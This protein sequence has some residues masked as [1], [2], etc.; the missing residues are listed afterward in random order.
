MLSIIGLRLAVCAPI[1][2]STPNDRP[3]LLCP[4]VPPLACRLAAAQLQLNARRSSVGLMSYLMFHSSETTA[5]DEWH[6]KGYIYPALVN[7]AGPTPLHLAPHSRHT[8]FERHYS[9][10][11]S[12]PS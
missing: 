9:F 10:Q 12:W 1:P 5:Q 6:D 8:R 3:P 2:V 7:G 11:H 4:I